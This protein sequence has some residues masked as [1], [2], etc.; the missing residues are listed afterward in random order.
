MDL[1]RVI[2]KDADFHINAV[3]DTNSWWCFKDQPVSDM[4][5]TEN[6]DGYWFMMAFE[7]TPHNAK[8]RLM[9]LDTREFP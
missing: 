4:S 7:A 2:T 8:S 9:L 6:L 5:T 1:R 3:A